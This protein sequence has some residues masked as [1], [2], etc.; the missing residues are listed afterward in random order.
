MDEALAMRQRF[1]DLA[2]WYV[3]GTASAAD[4]AWV[5]GYV[6]SHP[7]ARAELEWYASLEHEIRADA[8]EVPADAGLERL[9]NRVRLERR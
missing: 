6:R 2:P 5:D 3:N 7:E 8:P 1:L 4:R 9:V